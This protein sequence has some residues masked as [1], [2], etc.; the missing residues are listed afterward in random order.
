MDIVKD[1]L[2]RI[3]WCIEHKILPYVMR[4]NSCWFSE[5]S[6]F[7][8][9]LAAYANQP[10]LIKKMSPKEYIYKRQ[11]KNKARRENFISYFSQITK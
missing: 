3:N 7:Y 10:N 4:D 6:D 9:D 1:V 2:F 11:P 8:V 5:E